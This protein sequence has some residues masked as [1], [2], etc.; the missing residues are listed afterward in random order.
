MGKAQL[1]WPRFKALEIARVLVRFDHVAEL[2][3]LHIAL[4]SDRTFVRMA[5]I[6]ETTKSTGGSE[7]PG[8]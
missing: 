7:N 3:F 4:R 8:S 2:R 6:P 1:S 5:S